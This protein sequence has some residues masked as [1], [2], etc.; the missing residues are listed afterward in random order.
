LRDQTVGVVGFG[1][2]GR[3]VVQRLLAFGGTVRVFDPVVPAVEIEKVGASPAK[4]F[5]ELQSNCDILTLHCP[6]TAQTRRM[7]DDK[8]LARMKRGAILINLARGDLVV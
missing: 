8:A 6:S 3:A 1:R 2:I 5:A 4:T 7:I